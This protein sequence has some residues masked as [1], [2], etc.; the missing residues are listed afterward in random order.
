MDADGVDVEVLYCEVSAYR[1]LYLMSEGSYDATRAFN[2]ALLEFASVRST[3]PRR[4][5]SSAHP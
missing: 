5:G 4:D 1:Y 3:S 2:D